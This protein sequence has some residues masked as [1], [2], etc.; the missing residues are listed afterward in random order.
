MLVV[1]RDAPAQLMRNVFP[2]RGHWLRIRVLNRAGGDALGAFVEVELADRTVTRVVR[3]AYGYASS[4]DPAIHLGLG[5]TR[6][7]ARIRATWP[8]G[9]STEQIDVAGDRSIELTR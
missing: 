7:V 3:A 4:H 6:K 2:D 1:N 8:D 9:S 5:S